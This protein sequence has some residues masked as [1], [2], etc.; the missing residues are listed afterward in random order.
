[1]GVH[2]VLVVVRRHGRPVAVVSGRAP[3]LVPARAPVLVPGAPV[4]C[5][6]GVLVVHDVRSLA[7]FGGDADLNSRYP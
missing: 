1:M 3:V 2:H 6:A 5:R 7:K 4:D